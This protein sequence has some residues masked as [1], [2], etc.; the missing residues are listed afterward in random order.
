VISP[1]RIAI[2]ATDCDSTRIVFNALNREF[3]VCAVILERPVPRGEFLRRRFRKLGVRTVAGQLAFRALIAPVLNRQAQRR[4]AEIL[5]AHAL[6]TSPIDPT[7]RVPITSVNDEECR[8][9]L[10]LYAP[11]L[12]VVNGTRIISTTTLSST[13]ARFVN[14][15]TGLTPL[16]RGVH[17]GYWAL[18]QGRRDHFGVTIHFV[19]TGIDTGSVI[20][21][22]LA[23]PT[24][25]DTFAT[26]SY[27]QYAV[28]IPLLKEAIRQVLAG[29]DLPLTPLTGNSKLW[30]HP[31][32]GQYL[33]NLA[34]KGVW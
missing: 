5:A 1:K 7:V 8:E 31:T 28:G 13:T 15:H 32:I 3:N 34:R 22:A 21:Q 27:L 14:V 2:L 16:Y 23:Q 29:N 4:I 17:G 30:S 33:G 19:D 18:A 24:D 9:K 20:K 12:I 25:A 10:R 26:Y 11:D 6:D